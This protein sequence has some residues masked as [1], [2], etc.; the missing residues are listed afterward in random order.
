MLQAD[1][2]RF[3]SVKKNVDLCII[4]NVFEPMFINYSHFLIFEGSVSLLGPVIYDENFS[5]GFP[6]K[7]IPSN[8]FSFSEA[9]CIIRSGVRGL[10]PSFQGEKMRQSQFDAY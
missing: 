4:T 2:V 7:G 8:S 5:T 6:N 9:T 3:I 1:V 10:S